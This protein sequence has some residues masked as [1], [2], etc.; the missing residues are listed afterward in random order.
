MTQ[1]A[2]DTLSPPVTVAAYQALEKALGTKAILLYEPKW[3]MP[4]VTGSA[5]NTVAAGKAALEAGWEVG[6]ILD[7][8]HPTLAGLARGGVPQI[9]VGVEMAVE[10]L[11]QIGLDPATGCLQ[12]DLEESDWTATDGEPLCCE[13]SAMFVEACSGMPPIPSQYGNVNLLTGLAAKLPASQLA[14]HVWIAYYL[15]TSTWPSAL[16]QIP[17]MP[18]GMW[19]TAGQRGWQWHGGQTTQGFDLDFDVVDFPLFTVA[20]ATT[21]PTTDPTPKTLPSGKYLVP[22]GSLI[23]PNGPTEL[24]SGATLTVP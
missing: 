20:H 8:N 15:S 19:S 14:Q 5:Q 18:D 11:Q 12:F 17:T 7:P 3:G 10:T 21:D 16:A 9:K 6:L 2:V 22:V 13:L 24:T 1:R 23:S 4:D